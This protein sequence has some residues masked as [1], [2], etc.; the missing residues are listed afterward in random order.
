M[1]E[2]INFVDV[3]HIY[4]KKKTKTWGVLKINSD[5]LGTI[6]WC[7]QWRQYCFFPESETIFSENCLREISNFI[8][9]HQNDRSE[10]PITISGEVGDKR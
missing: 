5:D 1:S 7:P 8:V 10:L 3:S 2:Y 6:K 9:E 4:P